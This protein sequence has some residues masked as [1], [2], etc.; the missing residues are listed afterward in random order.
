MNSFIENYKLIEND[1]RESTEILLDLL[2][3]ECEEPEKI[4]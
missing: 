2:S 3:I 1:K 4:L